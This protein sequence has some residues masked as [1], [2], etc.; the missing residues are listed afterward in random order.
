[1]LTLLNHYKK[2]IT[3]LFLPY[4]YIL[5]ILVM[6]TSKQIVAPGD[7][8]PMNETVQIEGIEMTKGFNTIY[9]YSYSPMTPFQGLI[10]N[11]DPSIEIDELTYREKDTSGRDNFL[12][13]QVSKLS[14]LQIAVI[15]AYELAS[16]VDESIVINY[17]FEGLMLYYRPSR[18]NELKIG[19][20]ILSINGEDYSLHDEE[21]F[22]ELSR[23]REATLSVRRKNG[24]AYEYH[25]ISYKLTEDEP[26]LLYYP[27][28]AIDHAVPSFSLPG[29]ESVI[30]GPSGGMIQTLS[31]YTSLLNINIGDTK[32]AGTGTIE[33]DGT[34][35]RIGGIRQ[36]IYTAKYRKTDL[37]FI[38]ES[39]KNEIIDIPHNFE[40]IAI[41]T[42]EE[43]VQALHEAIN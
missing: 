27:N 20:E 18:L 2:I 19:D 42:I 11:L 4:L 31:I 28:Y 39:H 24:N 26:T 15:K 25:T 37:F 34:I 33:M 41:N 35:G 10:A 9:V 22:T 21:S 12:S 17:H 29:L 43:A 5:F 36:K 3:I 13:G 32:I 23:L 8:T 14:S 16:E 40:L 7:L 30:G 1:M 6:P 38:P